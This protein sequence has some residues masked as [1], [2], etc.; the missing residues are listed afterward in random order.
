MARMRGRPVENRGIGVRME[1]PPVDLAKLAEGQG[2]VGIGPVET[3]EAL[4]TAL[5]RGIEQ[6]R[7]GKVCVVDVVV[8]PEYA[9]VT[10]TGLLRK[11]PSG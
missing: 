11:L 6:V 9:R 8:A 10:S 1:D 2:A 5:A 7:A 3:L 4:E